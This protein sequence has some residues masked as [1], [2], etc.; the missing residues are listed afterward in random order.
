[1]LHFDPLPHKA[2][3]SFQ[4]VILPKVSLTG[5]LRSAT[6]YPTEA[7]NA[8]F[9][10]L[11]VSVIANTMGAQTETPQVETSSPQTS[12][13]QTSLAKTSGL[14]KLYRFGVKRVLDVALVVIAAP[15]VVLAVAGLALGIALDGGNPFYSQPRVGRG[16]RI[17]RMWKLRS[18]VAGADAALE[19]YLASDP[20]ARAEWD[21]TQKLKSDPRIT[22]FGRILRKSSLDELPQL[23]NVLLGDMSLVG[24]R[25]MMPSQQD[26]YPGEAYYRLR[27]GITGPWQVSRRNESTFADRARFDEHYDETLSFKTDVGLLIGTVRVVMRATGY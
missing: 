3:R 27:P 13:D 18:M 7:A 12:L 20:V 16:G 4:A 23:W 8:N 21:S 6:A 9:P 25:P 15:V 2:V 19:S 14:S 26:I 5:A 1:M 11:A 17:Y 24:P 10:L 22:R